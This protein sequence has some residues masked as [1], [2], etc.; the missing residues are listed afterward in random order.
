MQSNDSD[1]IINI[2]SNQLTFFT[3]KI[4]SNKSNQFIISKFLMTFQTMRLQP[5]NMLLILNI[6]TQN[7][8]SFVIDSQIRHR[9][10]MLNA[11]RSFIR[12]FCLECMRLILW[13][14]E[15]NMSLWKG[16]NDWSKKG[17]LTEILLKFCLKLQLWLELYV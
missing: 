11:K 8:S 9:S 14:W 6:H 12:K 16:T 2:H 13:W 17:R 15:E 10:R 1:S 5:T 7:S 3:P 4:T